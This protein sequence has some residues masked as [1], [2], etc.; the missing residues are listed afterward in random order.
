MTA[1]ASAPATLPMNPTSSIGNP[2][3][4]A[5]A[6]SDEQRVSRADAID[7]LTANGRDVREALLVVVAQAA[8]FAPGHDHPR[9]RECSG[10]VGRELLEVAVVIP[11]LQPHFGLR[12][13]DEVGARVLRDDV[14]A[15]VAGIGLRI[16]GEEPGPS[17]RCARSTRSV[18]RPCP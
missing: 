3:A 2:I 6:A 18:S 4:T 1:H 15:E 11:V 10:R 12:D 16:D 14:V 8:A 13:G 7:D 5:G 9:R 17:R